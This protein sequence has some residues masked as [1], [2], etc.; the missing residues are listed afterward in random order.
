MV[1]EKEKKV[2]TPEE[3]SEKKKRRRKIFLRVLCALLA[4]IVLFV[5]VTSCITVVSFRSNLQKTQ[6]F[7]S[8]GS[9]E[10]AL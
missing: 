5:G 9:A 6:L 2:L 7:S 8:V 4:A 3:K 10:L 1:K